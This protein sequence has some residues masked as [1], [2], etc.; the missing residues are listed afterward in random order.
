ME[1]PIIDGL[2]FGALCTTC[3]FYVRGP[4]Y[5]AAVA[6]KDHKMICQCNKKPEQPTPTKIAAKQEQLTLF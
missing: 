6:R 3:K 4:G 5:D 1:Y 2:Y